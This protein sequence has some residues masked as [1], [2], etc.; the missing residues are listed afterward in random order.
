VDAGPDARLA[1]TRE[2]AMAA[3][4]KSWRREPGQCPL[5]GVKRTKSKQGAMSAFDP[6]RTKAGFEMPHRSRRS[7]CAILSVEARRH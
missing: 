7:G 6:K 5:S 2:A 3:F 4:A 1:E